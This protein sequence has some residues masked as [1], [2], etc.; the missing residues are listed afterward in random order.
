MRARVSTALM[1]LPRIASNEAKQAPA[2]IHCNQFEVCTH[3]LVENRHLAYSALKERIKIK[4]KTIQGRHN[5]DYGHNL[6][7]SLC[8][9]VVTLVQV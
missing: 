6:Y 8:L 3:T 9:C 2:T 5:L 7:Y 4:S 1:S